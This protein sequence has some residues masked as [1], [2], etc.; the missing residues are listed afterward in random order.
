MVYEWFNNIQEWLL[1]PT[2]VLCG[3]RGHAGQDICQGCVSDLPVTGIAC[4]CCALPLA[5]GQ[6]CGTCL[7]RTPAYDRTRAAFLYRPPLDH[8]LRGLKF[9]RHLHVARVLGIL[10]ADRL[11]DG[12]DADHLPDLLLPVPLHPQRLRERGYNQALELARPL[13][14]ALGVALEPTACRRQRATPPQAGLDAAA[15]RRNL[16][17]AFVAER[18]VAGR[19]VAVVDDVMTTGSTAEAVANALRRAGAREVEI[20]VCARVPEPGA[21]TPGGY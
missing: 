4:R 17:Q 13:A 16:R 5:Q 12:L 11:A 9:Q 10:M 3:Q 21:L 20:W 1:P 14:A 2:C 7:K 19:R 6:V 18:V 8:L 15:R